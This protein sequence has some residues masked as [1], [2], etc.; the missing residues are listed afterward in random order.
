MDLRDSLQTPTGIKNI[1]WTFRLKFCENFDTFLVYKWLKMTMHFGLKQSRLQKITAFGASLNYKIYVRIASK[2]RVM[3][4]STI[5]SFFIV[6][7]S[8][9]NIIWQRVFNRLLCRCKMGNLWNKPDEYI[10]SIL[11]LFISADTWNAL[12]YI[13]YTSR[14]QNV[15]QIKRFVRKFSN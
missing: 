5:D 6:C 3:M 11:W 9:W 14:Q 15:E 2:Y 13:I 8:T 12:F 10:N 4:D 1:K 7:Q